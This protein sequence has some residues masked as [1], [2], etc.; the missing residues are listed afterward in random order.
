MQI[1]QRGGPGGAL[2]Q[3]HP[4][5]YPVDRFKGLIS[6]T[7]ASGARSANV[8]QW[9]ASSNFPWMIAWECL[10]GVVPVDPSAFS[11]LE[12]VVEASDFGSCMWGTGLARPITLSF[13]V[14]S[15]NVGLFSVGFRNTAAPFRSYIGTYTVNNPGVYQR[16]S[17]T[18]PGDTFNSPGSWPLTGNG[19]GLSICWDTGTAA[20]YCTAPGIWTA[21]NFVAALGVNK[22]M[23]VTG[24][25]LYITNVKL[26]V[27]RNATLFVPDTFAESLSKCRRYYKLIAPPAYGQGSA[28][29]SAAPAISVAVNQAV[30]NFIFGG[31]PMRGIPTISVGGA[32]AM[33]NG[34]TGFPVNNNAIA[35]ALITG[36][37]FYWQIGVSAAMPAVGIPVFL[38]ASGDN[39]AFVSADAEL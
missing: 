6:G 22:I 19:A 27:G 36:Y 23:N 13:D 38:Q 25:V 10:N 9:N 2:N 12:Y 24:Q 7:T 30:M 5:G 35:I 39:S 34:I 4:S 8:T 20:N 32:F 15:T 11:M 1:N 33:S 3:A 26:E 14:T 18:V 29:F 16:V 28:L 17:I 37:G 21:G 31:E